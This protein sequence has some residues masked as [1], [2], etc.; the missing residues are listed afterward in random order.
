MFKSFFPSSRSGVGRGG[1]SG[2]RGPFP[3]AARMSFP[4]PLLHLCSGQHSRG[5]GGGDQTEVR[6]GA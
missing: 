3:Q 5:L 6:R 4:P 1:S 2:G